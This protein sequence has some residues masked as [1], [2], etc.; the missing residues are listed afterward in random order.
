M[1]ALVGQHPGNDVQATIVGAAAR[2]RQCLHG[3]HVVFDDLQVVETAERLLS[4]LERVH[5]GPGRSEA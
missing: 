4:A 2:R 5:H 1:P 3:S